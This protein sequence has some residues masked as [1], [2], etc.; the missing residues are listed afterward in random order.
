MERIIYNEW[1]NNNM[2]FRNAEVQAALLTMSLSTRFSAT[3]A[4]IQAK[5]AERAER[6][7]VFRYPQ[8][9]KPNNHRR[10]SRQAKKE[11][12]EREKRGVKARWMFV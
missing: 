10:R 12:Y 1:D 5:R 11:S 9:R 2:W 6:A 8:I 7:D 4:E 3:F